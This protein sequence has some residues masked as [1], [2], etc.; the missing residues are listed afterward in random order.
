MWF[1]P[2]LLGPLGFLG[3]VVLRWDEIVI[4]LTGKRLAVLGQREVGKTHLITFLS[5]GSIPRSY[6]QTPYPEKAGK[7]RFD[8]RELD[9]R[10]KETTDVPGSKDSYAQWKKEHDQADVVLYLFR[11]DRLMAGDTAIETRVRDD[12][13]H[14]GRWL[15]ERPTR[16]PFFLIGTFCDLDPAYVAVPDARKGDYADRFHKLPIVNELILRGGG[17]QNAKLVLGS[18]KTVAQTEM[19]VFELFRRILE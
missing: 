6:R 3:F 1:W 8:L 11:A 19:L 5:T 10:L 17:A 12:L 9:L 4:A 2:L 13:H 7:R 18:M 16:P 14:I 15:S